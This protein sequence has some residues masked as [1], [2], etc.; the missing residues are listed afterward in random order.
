MEQLLENLHTDPRL[1]H[2]S[3]LKKLL[4]ERNYQNPLITRP[5]IGLGGKYQCELFV[6]PLFLQGKLFLFQIPAI[7]FFKL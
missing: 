4:Q 3:D 1:K 5:Y 7:K 2:L 6:G